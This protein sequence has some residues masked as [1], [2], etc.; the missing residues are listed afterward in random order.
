M[1]LIK[2]LEMVCS[3]NRLEDLVETLNGFEDQRIMGML[4]FAIIKKVRV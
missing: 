2:R 3:S 1:R 4:R